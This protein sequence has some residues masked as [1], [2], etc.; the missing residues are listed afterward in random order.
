[1]IPDLDLYR[2]AAILVKRYGDDAPIHAAMR[3]AAILEAGD[4]GGLFANDSAAR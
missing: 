3:A 1:M 4:L 2:A